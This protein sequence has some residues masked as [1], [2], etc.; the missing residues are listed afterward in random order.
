MMMMMMVIMM[1]MVMMIMIM[2]IMMPIMIIII[3][4]II[5][6]IIMIIIM[7]ITILIVIVNNNNNIIII[8]IVIV[9]IVITI[10]CGHCAPAVSAAFQGRA[11]RDLQMGARPPRRRKYISVTWTSR[12]EQV[13]TFCLVKYHGE[14]SPEAQISLRRSRYSSPHLA[15]APRPANPRAASACTQ[16]AFLTWNLP[17]PPPLPGPRQ[18][19]K[20]VSDPG[21]GGHRGPKLMKV[22]IV[23]RHQWNRNPRPQPQT[24]S[25][26]G[27]S[28]I[29]ELILHFSKLVI[30]GSS[31][32]RGFR[33]HW[34]NT[35]LQ[36]LHTCTYVRFDT[37]TRRM[38]W[39]AS[40]RACTWRQIDLHATHEPRPRPLT[41]PR[42]PS[43]GRPILYTAEPS[44]KKS[45]P[46]WERRTL[47]SSSVRVSD[48]TCASRQ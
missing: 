30:W 29:L 40:R 1:M 13:L 20:L 26:I 23:I 38:R 15:R 19:I 8:I 44:Q 12:P 32:S 6:I 35:C 33:F 31:W 28:N 18:E 48:C 9:I 42:N 2:I 24:F 4:I 14:V 17:H 25:K 7:I 37:T 11:A 3:M 27:V 39:K 5:I 46:S 43:F 10:L 45:I 34:L 41:V 47:E 21:M 16:H 36:D 22:H